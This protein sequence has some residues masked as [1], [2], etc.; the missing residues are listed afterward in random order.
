MFTVSVIVVRA[1]EDEES[2]VPRQTFNNNWKKVYKINKGDRTKT[3]RTDQ[4]T[5]LKCKQMT[6]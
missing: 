1:E 3:N 6:I 2:K 4:Q 5:E